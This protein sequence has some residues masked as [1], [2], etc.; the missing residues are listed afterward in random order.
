MGQV[1]PS[2]GPDRTGQRGGPSASSPTLLQ[3]RLRTNAKRRLCVCLRLKSNVL[4]LRNLVE[5]YLADLASCLLMGLVSALSAGILKTLQVDVTSHTSDAIFYC[6]SESVK[7]YLTRK[8]ES[9][10]ALRSGDAE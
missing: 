4:G 1:K 2:S 6:R 5:S 3:Q 10:A 7:L 8:S 9:T